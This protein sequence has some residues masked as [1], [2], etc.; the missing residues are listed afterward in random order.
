MNRRRLVNACCLV[1][2]VCAWTF[3]GCSPRRFEEE[4]VKANLRSIAKAYWM[5]LGFHNRPPRDLDE[6]RG[7]LA[8]LHAVEMS[9]A[10][11]KVLISPRDKQPFVIIVGAQPNA[12]ESTTILAYEKQG[13]GDTRYV[14]TT[15][16]TIVE[17]SNEEFAKASFAENHKPE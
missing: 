2:G 12:A 16:G 10:P 1:L 4:P 9:D 5:I 14:L 17:M 3:C 13:A 6:L 11:D 15:S 8:D 7:T